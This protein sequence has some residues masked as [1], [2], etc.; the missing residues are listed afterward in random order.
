MLQY[1]R[2]RA[3]RAAA[4]LRAEGRPVEFEHDWRYFS[5][6]L[7]EMPIEPDI[8]TLIRAA[9]EAVDFAQAAR[10]RHARK[11]KRGTEQ[12]E[13][14]LKQAEERLR[15]AMRP[16]KRRIGKIPYESSFVDSTGLRE[17][18]QRMQRE[19]RKLWKM[20][21]PKNKGGRPKIHKD[22]PKYPKPE[23]RLPEGFNS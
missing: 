11:S 12:R 6:T 15:K 20:K 13:I 17:A 16:I 1:N 23:F 4:Q 8:P 3:Y 7:H 18:S 5:G 19:R 14:D 9:D 10:R 22:F 2:S 21:G